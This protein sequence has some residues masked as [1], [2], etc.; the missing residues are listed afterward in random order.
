[1]YS[2]PRI[3]HTV[4]AAVM[5]EALLPFNVET[6]KTHVHLIIQLFNRGFYYTSVGQVLSL[7]LVILQNMKFNSK[8]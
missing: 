3:K 2:Q 7:M 8:Q 6:H 1:M 4:V 5:M